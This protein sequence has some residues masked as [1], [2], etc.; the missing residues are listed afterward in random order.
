MITYPEIV[1][2]SAL[3]AGNAMNSP[4]GAALSFS[5]KFTHWLMLYTLAEYIVNMQSSVTSDRFLTIFT[6]GIWTCTTF[7]D[8]HMYTREKK[9]VPLPYRVYTLVSGSPGVCS[10]CWNLTKIFWI[11][12]FVEFVLGIFSHFNIA[13]AYS[14]SKFCGAWTPSFCEFTCNFG[15]TSTP[16]CWWTTRFEQNISIKF[17]LTQN[18]N[19]SL[20]FERYHCTY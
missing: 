7:I 5:H 14:N 20:F 11:S 13:I 16:Q 1:P 12:Y 8:E 17:V 10:F 3:I 9:A 4:G 6:F 18:H 15:K 2:L 19:L